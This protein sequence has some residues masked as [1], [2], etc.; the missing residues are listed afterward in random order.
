MEAAGLALAMIP[1]LISAVEDFG[2]AQSCFSQVR[3]YREEAIRLVRL[4]NAEHVRFR[5]TCE[6][7]LQNV[8]PESEMRAM[9]RNPRRETW[10]SIVARQSRSLES[11]LNAI[12]GPYIELFN[13]MVGA[14]EGLKKMLYVGPDGKVSD[15]LLKRA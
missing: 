7:L 11:R 2:E 8:V 13:V 5:C 15:T 10:E 14:I 3:N 9:M 4:F 12:F 6:K 1:L